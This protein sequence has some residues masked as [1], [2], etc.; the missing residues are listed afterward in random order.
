MVSVG[1]RRPGPSGTG[2]GSLDKRKKTNMGI[3]QVVSDHV[4]LLEV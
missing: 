3:P 1:F 4:L 2:P